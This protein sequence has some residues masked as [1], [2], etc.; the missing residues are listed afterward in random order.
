MPYR[1]DYSRR[2]LDHLRAL[3]AR[4]QTITLS[5]IEAQL[6]HTPG[7]ETRNRKLMRPNLLASWELR[8]GDVRVFYNLE[9]EPNQAVFIVAVGIKVR[10]RL[11]IGGEEYAL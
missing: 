4:Q 1:I 3:A 2:A 6:V 9:D 5:A 10:N 7:V 11:L 8:I